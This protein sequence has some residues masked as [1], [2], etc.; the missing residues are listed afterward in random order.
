MTID[1]LKYIGAFFILIFVQAL[2]LNHINLGGYIN[3]YLYVLFILMLPFDTPSWIVLVASFT[4]GIGVDIFSDSYG[5]HAA[6]ATFAGYSRPLVL[7]VIK[8]R[9]GYEFSNKP[10]IR[11]M[12]MVWYIAYASILVFLHHFV[13]FY[14]EIFRFSEFFS[15][16]LRII[17]STLFTMLI[18]ILSQ[19]LFSKPRKDK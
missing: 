11:D 17:L 12:G 19:L 14:I 13:F 15:V 7:G 2:V 18:I 8:P 6:A 9:D 16:L 10:T 5:M 1:I 4:L 3:P